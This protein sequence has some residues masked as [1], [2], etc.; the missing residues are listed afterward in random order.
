M[1]FNDF[2]DET[3]VV[4]LERGGERGLIVGP[5]KAIFAGDT[6][7]LDPQ[8]DVEEGD[9]ILRKLPTGKEERRHVTDAEFC[10]GFSD[11]DHHYQVK[12]R[13]GNSPAPEAP[14]SANTIHIH[15]IHGGQVQIGDHNTQNIVNALQELKHKIDSANASPDQKREAIG[16]LR[17]LLAHPLVTSVLGGLAGGI[18][19]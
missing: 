16:L 12:F 14:K 11:D 15:G 2:T 1:P 13:K 10:R 17:T 3:E 4:Y 9:V 18:T 7:L 5:Y 8:S 19:G 6:V